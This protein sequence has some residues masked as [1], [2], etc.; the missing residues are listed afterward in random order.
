M[1]TVFAVA[2]TA[3]VIAASA[4]AQRPDSTRRD[5]VRSA[6]ADTIDRS[7]V[8]DCVPRTPVA[9]DRIGSD[10]L[11]LT[12]HEAIA[13]AQ[14]RNPQLHAVEEQVAQARARKVQGTA[15]PDP[16]LSFDVN[17]GT[18][19]F[20]GR[21]T[22]KILAATVTIPFPDKFRLNGRIGSAD[23][24]ANEASLTLLRQVI[25]SQ[26]SQSY[27]SLL[28]SI[29]HRRNQVETRQL[30]ED[31]LRKT[32]ARFQA[33]TSPR[34]DVIRARVEVAQ[35]ENDLIASERDV[36]NARAALNRL[37]ARSLSAPIAAS[38][39]LAVPPALPPLE[40]L[41]AVALASRPELTNLERQQDGAHATTALARE[42]WLPDLTFGVSHNYADPGPGVLSTGVA[43]PLPIL[44]WQRSKG[45]LAESRHRELELAATY[46][47][48]RAQ[49]GQDVRVAYG[50]AAT[51][52]RQAIFLRDQL[53]PAAR[54][55]Y[56]IA[57]VSYGLGGSS[58]LDVLEARRALRD[59]ENQ[60]TDA[61]A[62]ANMARADLERAASRSLA[63]LES[64]GS[65]E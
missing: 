37:L 33:G 54:E 46:R 30:A 36:V 55:A 51:A 63:S 39:T 57:S 16:A 41:E 18:G 49:V 53:V 19:V 58:A 32:E 14:L 3:L 9:P 50:T 25:A 27:D 21:A 44:F 6:R 7:V 65:R 17:Q 28:A 1:R 24:Q 20:G 13:A 10:S 62:A 64:G 38:D 40:Q 15:I 60:Y 12:R 29:R 35:A 5:S 42:Y 23:V 4:A 34:L 43:L 2:M 47:D 61:L 48:L 26:T 8:P 31:F 59:A 52:L 22:D 11:C 56:R 45:A